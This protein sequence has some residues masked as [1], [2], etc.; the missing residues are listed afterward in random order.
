MKFSKLNLIF[1]SLIVFPSLFQTRALKYWKNLP[2]TD[3]MMNKLNIFGTKRKK[4]KIKVY[5]IFNFL[6]FSLLN[7]EILNLS[8]KISF[9]NIF[10]YYESSLEL[11]LQL[12]W[13]DSCLSQTLTEKTRKD[14]PPPSHSPI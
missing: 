4:N 12:R 14:H 10:F 11:A 5:T 2:F 6:K 7:R 1:L 13:D 9:I 3:L 8:K